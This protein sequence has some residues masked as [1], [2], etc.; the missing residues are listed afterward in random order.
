MNEALML[1]LEGLMTKRAGSVDP[2]KFPDEQFD[3]YSIP[4]FDKGFHEVVA[5]SEIGS[6]KQVVETKSPSA[7]NLNN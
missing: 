7:I 3:L 2:S 1:P 6:T 4:A 5:G